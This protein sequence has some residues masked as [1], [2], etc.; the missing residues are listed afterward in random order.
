VTYKGIKAWH[1]RQPPNSETIDTRTLAGRRRRNVWS[2]TQKVNSPVQGTAADGF[3]AALGLLWQ[4]RAQCPSARP[5]L[6]VHDEVVL[7]CDATEVETTQ[8]WLR[9]AVIDG[10]Q[11]LLATVPAD[12]D[13]TSG[14]DWGHCQ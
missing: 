6:L 12:A 1:D 9:T 8:A 7:E 11:P 10:L 3:K 4:R 14:P 5:V 2:F 13:V